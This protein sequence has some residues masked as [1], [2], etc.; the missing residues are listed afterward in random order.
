MGIRRFY[1]V[2]TVI[3]LSFVSL[4]ASAQDLLAKQAPID[5]HMRTLDTLALRNVVEREEAQMPASQLYE[6]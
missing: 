1:Y 3:V 5:K 4:C 6:D 2:I